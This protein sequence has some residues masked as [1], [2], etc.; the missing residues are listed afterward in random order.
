MTMVGLLLRITCMDA[1]RD[2][3]RAAIPA[4]R[5]M[6]TALLEKIREDGIATRRHIDVVAGGLRDDMRLIAERLVALNAKVDS[7]RQA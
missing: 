3:I 1:D 4:V 6:E 7:M 5:Q 2:D